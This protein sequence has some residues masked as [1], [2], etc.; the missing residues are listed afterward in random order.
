MEA[1]DAGADS[2]KEQ[3]WVKDI[4]AAYLRGKGA[5]DEDVYRQL[6]AGRLRTRQDRLDATLRGIDVPDRRP[7][8]CDD[9][10][11]NDAQCCAPVCGARS[12][13]PR[14]SARTNLPTDNVSTC[15]DHPSQLLTLQSLDPQL[16]SHHV[17]SVLLRL[18][19]LMFLDCLKNLSFF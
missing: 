14:T 16:S 1:D 4:L 18:I 5:S 6:L 3:I 15:V 13:R 7:G 2:E 19:A 17:T 8:R 10:R 9:G 11:E 12:Y